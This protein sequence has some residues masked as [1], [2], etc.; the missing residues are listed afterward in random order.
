MSGANSRG[1]A[2]AAAVAALVS[3]CAAPPHASRCAS[4]A[5]CPADSR[6]R[7]G[8][9]VA[10]APPV[11]RI[12]LPSALA[13]NLPLH[14]DALGSYDPD[15]G[16]GVTAQ[17]WAVRPVGNVPANCLPVPESGAGPLLTVVFPC[18][19]DFEIELSVA[20][21]LGVWSAPLVEQ[22]RVASS[23][24]P[25]TVATGASLR[26]DHAC[27]GKP[28]RCTPL[29][30]AGAE[31]FALSAEGASPAGTAFTYRWTFKVPPGLA[32]PVP[33]V[34]FLP[35][36]ERPSPTVLLETDGTAIAGR[37]TFTVE[38]TDARGMVAVGLQAVEVGN[39]PPA[40]SGAGP[41]VLSVPHAFVAGAGGSGSLTASGATPPLSVADPDGDPV[42]TGFE[43]I[44]SGDGTGAFVL[45]AGADQAAFSILVVYAG[46]A[47]GR[48]LIGPDVL[49][50]IR[51]TA[52]DPNGG[53][54]GAEW[55]VQVTNRP[56]R[57][58]A[59]V[60]SLSVPHRF[61]AVRSAYLASATL[62][63]FTDDDG[64]PLALDASTGSQVCAGV[65][66]EGPAARVE[67]SVPFQGTPAANLLAGLHAVTA[68]VRDPWS[69][70]SA[71]TG[72]TIENRAPRLTAD[73]FV[74]PATCSSGTGCCYYDTRL[75]QCLAYARKQARSSGSF[76]PPVVDD[77]GDP[78]L[79]DYAALDACA[80]VSPS[81]AV[82]APGACPPVEPTLCGFAQSCT[83]VSSTGSI[84]VAATDG[85]L[86]V[87]GTVSLA[88]YCG[89]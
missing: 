40:V 28:L 74:L 3:A 46:P 88:A 54:T 38:A 49:R 21:A 63:S 79:L 86:G 34:R 81:S 4:A 61:D 18:G 68:T 1:R 12:G 87:V 80:A 44:H 47:D 52:R 62:A 58:T 2:C 11:A 36:A 41:S 13:S 56:P 24:V 31:T 33:R 45:Q 8:L 26:L 75:R 83:V 57:A 17:A 67:C 22:L 70:A 53:A 66:R 37:W 85:D 78:L 43:A 50:T 32:G 23:P 6:C 9:C 16:D 65:G 48:Y 27:S 7:S 89:K 5:D 39:R 25:P 73:A 42:E 19:G 10:D 55:E 29:D 76:S 84:S 51:F 69:S 77:D 72:L 15:P 20:D 64:D 14:F 60:P 71:T 59:T 30:P 82:C 35:D